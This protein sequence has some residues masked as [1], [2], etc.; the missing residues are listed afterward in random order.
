MTDRQLTKNNHFVPKFYLKRFL[1]NSNYLHFYDLQNKKYHNT[2]DLSQVCKQ[3][4]LYLIKNKITELDKALFVKIFG[5]ES[6]ED[7][8]FCHQMT[9]MLNGTSAN[10]ISIKF[11]GDKELQ[12]E[13]DNLI[14]ESLNCKNYS[15]EQETLFTFIENDF[16]VLY[17]NNII[18]KQTLPNC[19]F[20]NEDI[21]L[22]L[23]IKILKYVHQELFN[24]LKNTIKANF[25]NNK[26]DIPK[27]NLLKNMK[28][29]PLIDIMHYMLSQYFRTKK[30]INCIKNVTATSKD[31]ISKFMEQTFPNQKYD[32]DNLIFLFIHI[33]PILLLK[34]LID[35]NYR[36]ILLKNCTYTPFLISDNP[37]INTY[38]ETNKNKYKKE[39]FEVY[40]PLTPTLAL[41]LTMNKKICNEIDDVNLVDDYNKK[42]IKNAERYI[43]A[44]DMM[45]LK[46]YV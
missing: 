31:E 19:N 7:K 20:Q 30:V 44:N 37:C 3:K 33:E 43:F 32:I 26:Q 12:R 4:N 18:D 34:N 23:Y 2:T 24:R 39:E 40:F 22:Y 46:K 8:D 16:Q 28:S 11:N 41:L 6:L 21:K 45:L 29:R 13:I 5:N 36:L 27:L 1:D 15:M 25:K 38:A 10:L 9:E 17:Q 35:D 42:I 14:S